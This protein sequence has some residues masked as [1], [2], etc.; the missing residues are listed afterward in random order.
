F[1]KVIHEARSLAS[2]VGHHEICDGSAEEGPAGGGG[3]E[4]RP[5]PQAGPSP[6]PEAVAPARGRT[7]A[8]GVLPR[9]PW[10]RR[11]W[12]AQPAGPEGGNVL[13]LRHLPRLLAGRGLYRLRSLEKV[14]EPGQAGNLPFWD[15]R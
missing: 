6:L 13:R 9:E 14:L 12:R 4:P 7:G 5:G 1:P 2:R 15:Q 10:G 8:P 11:P 3:R